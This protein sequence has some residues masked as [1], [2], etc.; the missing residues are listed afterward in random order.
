MPIEIFYSELERI[1]SRDQDIEELGNGYLVA[2][3]LEE[4]Y[5]SSM[6][7]PAIGGDGDHLAIGLLY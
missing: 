5:S 2:E 3:G 6:T 1:V 7:F 4:G